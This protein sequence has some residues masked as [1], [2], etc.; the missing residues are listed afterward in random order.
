MI[1]LKVI[2]AKQQVAKL[3]MNKIRSAQDVSGQVPEKS[4]NGKKSKAQKKGKEKYIF[5]HM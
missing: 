4:S 3:A 1:S 5:M 2:L